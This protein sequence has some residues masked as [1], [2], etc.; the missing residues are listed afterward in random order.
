MVK[1]EPRFGLSSQRSILFHESSGMRAM[2]LSSPA[3]IDASP[4]VLRDF[5]TPQPAMKEIRVK[6]EACAICRTDLHICEGELPP[7]RPN[8]VP[9][10]QVVGIIDAI[11]PDATRFR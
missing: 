8:V 1:P 2:A 4:L 11:G 3:S 7:H 6:V 5:P 10:H 9:G